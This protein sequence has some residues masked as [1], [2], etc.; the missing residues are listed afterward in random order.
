MDQF[1][2]PAPQKIHALSLYGEKIVDIACGWLHS[3]ALTH[4]GKVFSWGSSQFNQTGTGLGNTLNP[5]ECEL[6]K[7]KRV[8]SIDGGLTHSIALTSKIQH[9]TH[10]SSSR[11]Q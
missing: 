7:G 9:Q 1:F 5:K 10:L 11:R 3:F 2:I 6:L 4:K 8:V